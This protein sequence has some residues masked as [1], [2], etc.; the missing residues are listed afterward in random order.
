MTAHDDPTAQS[1][2]GRPLLA[3][4]AHLVPE[5]GACLME[6]ASMLAG[7][8][9]SDHPSCTDP[10]L[11][12]LA[13]LV[14]DA[15]TDSGRD[16]LLPLAATLAY[17]PPADVIG[18]AR[19]VLTVVTTAGMTA[20]S[21]YR[22]GRHERAARRRLSRVTATGPLAS[23]AR[24]L[25]IAHRRGGGRRRLE[26]AVRAVAGLPEADRNAALHQLL[27]IAVAILQPN[28]SSPGTPRSAP[29]AAS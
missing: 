18:S 7:R 23:L 15:C 1:A 6:Y 11:G 27:D 5:D 19:M 9:F 24:R 13:R 3:V 10:M 14:N 26:A 21:R 20:G 2:P 28:V 16:G 25:E 4:G 29:V 8:P 22:L 12:T 17:T